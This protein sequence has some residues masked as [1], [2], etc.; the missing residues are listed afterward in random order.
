MS[1]RVNL[2]PTKFVDVRDGSATFGVR[3]Y[4]DYDQGYYN[5]W[6]AIPDD[7]MELLRLALSEISDDRFLSMISFVREEDR[8]MY[9]GNTWYTHEELDPIFEKAFD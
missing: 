7:D 2:E 1:N 6:D 5:C 9:I 8:G 4:D 3:F